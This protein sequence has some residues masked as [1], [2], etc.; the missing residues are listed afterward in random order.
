MGLPKFKN[1]HILLN[2]ISQRFLLAIKLYA[3]WKDPHYDF[4]DENCEAEGFMV[5]VV[6]TMSKM[7]NFKW[8]IEKYHSDE[9]ISS[10]IGGNWTNLNAS[11]TGI[12]G[13]LYKILS[14]SLLLSLVK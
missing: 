4:L 6:D 5:D 11:F 14:F 1:N 8:T 3:G 9:W 12:F 13:K 2:K 7:F 10:P